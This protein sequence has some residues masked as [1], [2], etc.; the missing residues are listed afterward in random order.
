MESRKRNII[1]VESDP[2][3]QQLLELNYR[4]YTDC[5][6]T[7]VNNTE[8][9]IEVLGDTNEIDLIVCRAFI[10]GDSAA[11]KIAN[12]LD[13]KVMPI[14]LLILGTPFDSGDTTLCETKFIHLK[15][16][17]ELQHIISS[18]A[19][20]LNITA[21][22]MAQL[23]TQDFYPIC[24]K[25][26]KPLKISP[27]SL[28][29]HRPV[30]IYIERIEVGSEIDC[31]LLKK[32]IQE[33]HQELYVKSGQRLQLTNQI[34]QGYISHIDF[35]SLNLD[36]QLA[37]IQS[38]QNMIRDNLKLLGITPQTVDLAKKTIGNIGSMCK[39]TPG[40]SKLLKRLLEDP[41]CY[42]FQHGHIITYIGFHLLE[43][44]DWGTE[45]Q[46]EKL[47]FMAF[48]HDIYLENDTQAM[49]HSE[50]ELNASELDERE[51]ELVNKHAQLAAELVQKIPSGPIGIDII[52][53]QHHGSLNGIGFSE[54]FGANLSP[55]AIVFII[56][57]HCADL[58]INTKPSQLSIELVRSSLKR[59]FPTARF[60]K[61][62][63]IIGQLKL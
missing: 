33:G 17:I 5:T 23:D 62:I 9:C 45:E 59:K 20:L 32:L 42:L 48:F 10:E 3:M 41:R 24:I 19:Q 8:Q 36:E 39:K 28:Y 13:Q 21:K 38:N 34:S 56:A 37:Q 63:D 47:A 22:Q 35:D 60:T 15:N 12:F 4:L 29:I 2:L 11:V 27:V 40:L 53:K 7:S 55:L 58:V 31:D 54:T 18:S 1:V 49:I 16:K 43:N 57:E 61:F 46:Q 6:T 44:I 52:I 25:Y 30:D 14:P 51:K 26:F 50:Q